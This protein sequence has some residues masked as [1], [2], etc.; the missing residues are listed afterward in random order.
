MGMAFTNRT[1]ARDGASSLGR[2]HGVL[3]QCG[4]TV[5]HE[6]RAGHVP[7]FVGCEVKDAIGHIQRLAEPTQRN[8]FLVTLASHCSGDARIPFDLVEQPLQDRRRRIAWM[9][10]VAPDAQRRTE[11]SEE[12]TSE[13]QSL[14]RISY[15]VY[16][17]KT[18][19]TKEQNKQ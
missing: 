13:L 3:S 5:D 19:K 12:N 17:L 8:Q 14:M 10:R 4:A 18:T 11:R 7:G 2:L 16:C 15:A 6:L 1:S 9:D